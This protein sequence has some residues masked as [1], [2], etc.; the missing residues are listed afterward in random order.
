MRKVLNLSQVYDFCMRKLELK[1]G[2]GEV[3]ADVEVFDASLRL[4]PK[5]NVE[6]IVDKKSLKICIRR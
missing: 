4:Y 5:D 2:S 3:L 6:F 1:N